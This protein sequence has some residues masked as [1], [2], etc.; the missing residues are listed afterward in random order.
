MDILKLLIVEDDEKELAICESSRKRYEHEKSRLIKIVASKTLNDAK[1][2]LNNSFDGAIVDLKLSTVNDRYEGNVIVKEIRESYR[3]PIAILTGTPQNAEIENSF[4]GVYTRG[5]I[6]FVELFDL[7]YQ[8]YDTG[9]TK[10]FG[11]RG[12]IEQEMDNIFWNSIKPNFE[13]WKIYTQKGEST[14]KGLL[15]FTVSHLLELLDIDSDTYYPEEMYVTSPHLDGTMTGNIVKDNESG[16]NYIVLSPAC[17]LVVRKNGNFKTDSVLVCFIE[18]YDIDITKSA[19][20]I[21]KPK[22]SEGNKPQK[23]PSRKEKDR[24]TRELEKLVANNSTY[25]YH[26][27]PKTT[28]FSGGIINFRKTNSFSPDEFQERFSK[29]ITRIAMLFT[30]DIIARFSSFYARQGQPDFDSASLVKKLLVDLE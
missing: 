8:I 13:E 24:A 3:I 14:E 21:L 17:D 18:N 22:D 7:F 11:G 29:P 19:T 9:L 20:S 10:I 25:Y 15:R 6:E 2:M 1:E 28:F 30:K 5:E 4:L 16:E 26:Y 27:L 12:I 23:Q